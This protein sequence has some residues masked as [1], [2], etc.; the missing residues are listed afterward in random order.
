MPEPFGMLVQPF[1][2]EGGT[3]PLCRN[4]NTNRISPSVRNGL[5]ASTCVVPK[6]ITKNTSKVTPN[7]KCFFIIIN[8]FVLL[9]MKKDVCFFFCLARKSC[10]MSFTRCLLCITF[11]SI[12]TYI[13]IR[14]LIMVLVV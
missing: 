11:S 10:C 12:M 14:F 9:K 3:V 13:Y 4:W 2:P 1:G 8:L 5:A 6:K 7:I